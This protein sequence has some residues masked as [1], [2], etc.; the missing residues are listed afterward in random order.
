M[1][2]NQDLSE[3]AMKLLTHLADVCQEHDVDPEEVEVTDVWI[4]DDGKLTLR[5]RL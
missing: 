4:S 1:E 3:F 5:S 2:R